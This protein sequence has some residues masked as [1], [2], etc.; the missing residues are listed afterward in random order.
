M[1]GQIECRGRG[2]RDLS[3]QYWRGPD[4]FFTPL[5]AETGA[6]SL[7]YNIT[8]AATKGRVMF[9][10][11]SDQVSLL[12]QLSE[13][14]CDEK[15]WNIVMFFFTTPTA[16]TAEKQQDVNQVSRKQLGSKTLTKAIA[17]TCG[18]VSRLAS[19]TRL[20]T[21]DYP[22]ISHVRPTKNKSKQHFLLLSVSRLTKP[23]TSP[24]SIW[25]FNS[26]SY[27]YARRQEQ[28]IQALSVTSFLPPAESPRVWLL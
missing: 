23:K 25:W 22:M 16:I 8:A 2:S 28:S 20:E 14:K 9:V 17:Q 10:S 7:A 5:P 21:K 19:L 3:P 6:W 27:C 26:C 1:H 11:Q 13:G 18:Q 12:H 15:T 24:W 4:S